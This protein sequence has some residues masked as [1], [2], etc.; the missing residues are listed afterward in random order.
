M[1]S[2]RSYDDLGG[3]SAAEGG[4]AARLDADAGDGQLTVRPVT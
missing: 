1:R 2:G 4:A 3:L